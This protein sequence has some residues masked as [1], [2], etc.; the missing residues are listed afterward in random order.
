MGNQQ[1]VNTD[2]I[3]KEKV[4][5]G[6]TVMKR[7]SAS[8][9]SSNGSINLKTISQNRK[10]SLFS[11]NSNDAPK[12]SSS[13]ETQITPTVDKI[14]IARRKSSYEKKKKKNL[15][16]LTLEKQSS[17]E[18]LGSTTVQDYEDDD[19]FSLSFVDD[20]QFSPTKEPSNNNN[21]SMR[22]NNLR[23]SYFT[24]LVTSNKWNIFEENSSPFITKIIFDWDDLFQSSYFLTENQLYCKST[25][26]S[27]KDSEKFVKV[28]FNILRLLT[29]AIEKGETYIVTNSEKEWIYY[30][31]EHFYPS[32]AKLKDKVKII[33]AKEEFEKQ[34][35][36]EPKKWKFIA[37][38]NIIMKGYNSNNV[39]NVMYFG[40]IN[41]DKKMKTNCGNVFL[42]NIKV[43][44]TETLELV[45]KQLGLICKEFVKIHSMTKNISMKIDK[46]LL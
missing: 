22:L 32:L 28:E 6:S 33:S 41:F 14:N 9:A 2:I 5:H 30:S 42:K 16:L 39:Y 46:R 15:Y 17:A 40:D 36:G 25:K 37:F 24:K 10:S 35:M 18:S 19:V 7:H 3:I 12:R 45:N 8:S 27:L 11:S 44:P 20:V 4:K 13:L 34:F 38:K 43:I 31:I 1:A 26:M 23:F 29:M 21:T